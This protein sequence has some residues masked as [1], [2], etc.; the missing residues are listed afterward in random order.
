MR[1]NEFIAEDIGRRGFLG[2]LLGAVA[3]GATA[4]QKSTSQP[5]STGPT[6][7]QKPGDKAA[8]Q[9][10]PASAPTVS[11]TAKNVIQK[12]SPE[13]L[14]KYIIDYAKKHLPPNQVLPFIAQVAHES[15]NFTQMEENLNYR[16]QTLSKKYPKTFTS[17]VIDY[18]NKS[19]NRLESIA[20]LLYSNRMGNGNYRSGDGYRYRGRGY[21]HLTGRENYE[22]I[23]KA[24]GVDLV[25]NPDLATR[26]D[27]AAQIA[28]IYWKTRVS[29]KVNTN[30]ISQV[31]KKISGS[32]K[33]GI[34]SRVDKLKKYAKDLGKNKS[35]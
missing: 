13:Q 6:T 23:G 21:I 7:V 5:S 4:S 30:D 14:E 35:K 29:N 19:A 20:N 3:T 11:S 27:L 31:T 8:S 1:A 12:Y 15:H 17:S 24:L 22:R 25:G 9:P 10:Q 16:D 34:K 18:I 26:P 32:A 28:L 33:Q 2:G